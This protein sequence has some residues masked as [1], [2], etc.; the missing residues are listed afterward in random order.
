MNVMNNASRW[1]AYIG[2]IWE[3]IFRKI[4]LKK[5]GSIIEVAPGSINKIGLGLKNYGFNG[6]VYIIEPNKKSLDTITNNYK[7]LLSQSNIIPIRKPLSDITNN[8]VPLTSCDALV[9]N[10]PLDD[11]I[12]GYLYE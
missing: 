5:T 4:N 2:S 10:H 9:S 8:D 12:I 11:M 3:D 6:K 7:Q 1:N